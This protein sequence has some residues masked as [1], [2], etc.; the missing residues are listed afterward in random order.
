MPADSRPG[1]RIT[2]IMAPPRPEAS[3][4]RNAATSGEP[5]R[6]L[7]A[8]KLP[9]APTTARLW[10]GASRL[11]SRTAETASPPPSAIRGASGPI[12]APRAR[13]ASAASAMPG[14]AAAAA[15]PPPTLS[16]SAGEWPPRPGRYLMVS[17]TRTPATGRGSSGHQDGSDSKPSPVV[18]RSVKIHVWRWLTSARK[19]YAITAMGAPSMAASTSRRR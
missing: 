3:I 6:V 11:T 1:T 19:K 5:R 18:G 2:P 10:A 12:T 4:I 17:A 7:I 13:P 8:A 16:P 9:A 14:R 15:G